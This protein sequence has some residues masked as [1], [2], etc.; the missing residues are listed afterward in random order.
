M[1]IAIV[2][3]LMSG[4]AMA[5]A[6]KPRDVSAVRASGATLLDKEIE[7]TG[8]V[9]WVY[10]CATELHKVE[11]AK[12]K[13]VTLAVIKKRIEEDGTLCERK[14]LRLGTTAKDASDKTILVVDVPR[15]PNKL[16]KAHLPKDELAKW[17][18]VPNV[19]AGNRV[20]I[21]GMWRKMSP[22]SET[23]AFGSG[24]LVY[25]SLVPAK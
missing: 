18:K 4:V 16:E 25:G 10:D 14:K 13:K 15:P 22:H 3:V 21:T 12:D 17:P 20:T 5:D 1:R 24:V 7:V 9:T 11:A 2:L 8:V 6:P 19:A 23:D